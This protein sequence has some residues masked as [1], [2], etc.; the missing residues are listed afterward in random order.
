MEPQPTDERVRHRSDSK[1]F[2]AR[3]P[4]VSSLPSAPAG[5]AE[6]GWGRKAE[7]AGRGTGGANP[8]AALGGGG[9]VLQII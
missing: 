4:G 6:G 5:F 3:R 7:K 9:E 8:I 2:P 1:K